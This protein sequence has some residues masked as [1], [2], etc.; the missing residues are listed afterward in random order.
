MVFFLDSVPFAWFY[1]LGCTTVAC[2]INSNGTDIPSGCK[3]NAPYAG[4][5]VPTKLA[6]FYTQGCYVEFRSL[7]SMNWT[8]P[9][10]GTVKVAV[11]AGGGGGGTIF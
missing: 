5:I 1:Y 4:L 8:A 7:G 2:P 10:T 11:V 6:C 3:C 9:I